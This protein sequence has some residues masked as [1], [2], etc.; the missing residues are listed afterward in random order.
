MCRCRNK[1][2]GR[3]VDVLL[4]RCSELIEFAPV[5]MRQRIESLAAMNPET[6]GDAIEAALAAANYAKT[7][8]S[9]TKFTYKELEGGACADG[10]L[11]T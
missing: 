7:S 8:E 4:C 2:Y 10:D 3:V 5:S 1:V 11:P 9:G 6:R